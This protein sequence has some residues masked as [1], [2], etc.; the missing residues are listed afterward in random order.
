MDGMWDHL[1]VN[2]LIN[3]QRMAAIKTIDEQISKEWEAG[4]G[5]DVDT[6]LERRHAIVEQMKKG[7]A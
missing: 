5:C 3:L 4:Y 7:M 6:L 1:P 2:N